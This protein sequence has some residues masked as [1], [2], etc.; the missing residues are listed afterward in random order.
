MKKRMLMLLI[1]ATMVMAGCTNTASQQETTAVTVEETTVG[2]SEEVTEPVEEE[3]VDTPTETEFEGPTL[4][5][6]QKAAV[7]ASIAAV[8]ESMPVEVEESGGDESLLATVGGVMLD[9]QPGMDIAAVLD[10]IPGL[11]RVEE[12]PGNGNL[13]WLIDGNEDWTVGAIFKDG[14][15]YELSMGRSDI[16]NSNVDGVPVPNDGY[17]NI[18]GIVLGER[19]GDDAYDKLT[20]MGYECILQPAEI[21]EYVRAADDYSYG[22]TV[23]IWYG[24]VWSL[25]IRPQ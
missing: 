9:L 5:D 15:F 10:D 12:D 11:T 13:Y 23:K 25:I 3:P 14:A 7:D 6:E 18:D 8:L 21:G 22:L 1:G 4:S 17:A 20:A 24:D 19:L 2:E 16:R